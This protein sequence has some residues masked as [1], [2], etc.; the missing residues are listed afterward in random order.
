M[1]EIMVLFNVGLRCRN[2]QKA[3]W[4]LEISWKWNGSSANGKW[5]VL[6]L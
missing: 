1:A 4:F 2:I 3:S 5:P 6:V